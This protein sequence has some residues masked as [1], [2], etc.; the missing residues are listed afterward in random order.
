MNGGVQVGLGFDFRLAFG[1]DLTNYFYLDTSA[2]NELSLDLEVTA[3]GLSATGR[4]GLLD[5]NVT[6]SAGSPSSFTASFDVDL[7]DPVGVNDGDKLT[8]NE[9]GALG[10]NL[11][12]VFDAR[13]SGVADVNLDTVVSF[14]SGGRFPSL[15]A[16]FNLDW[17]F[18]NTDTTAGGTGFGSTPQ[19]AFNNVRL[20]VGQFLSGFAKP[21]L[22]K[23]RDLTEPLQPIIDAL[24]TPI[25]ILSD[26]L[27][28]N[29][30]L[31]DV[32]DAA[33]D[34]YG[35]IQGLID[36]LPG[37]GNFN[38]E[39][40][41]D[42]RFISAAADIIDLVNSIPTLGPNVLI[43]LGSFDLS[44]SDP[45]MLSDLSGVT[46]GNVVTTNPMDE[47]AN[48]PDGSAAVGFFTDAQQVGGGDSPVRFPILEN[49]FEA[50][51]LLLGKSGVDLFIY[52]PLALAAEYSFSVPWVIPHWKFSCRREPQGRFQ[53]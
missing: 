52:D 46:P 35:V 41:L 19:V 9:L 17:Q 24:Q 27:G 2:A 44:G 23:I 26:A 40:P 16:E 38:I 20:D 37:G 39:T 15:A 3:P 25:P 48:S 51:K 50:F 36:Q 21:V 1:V 47:L 5:L 14:G 11:A 32:A 10:S 28:S 33:Q 34:F 8:L 6:D 7:I 22:E 43:P 12:G 45:R 4:L 13:F 42:I 30:T 18:T 53:R 29:V 49:P 31:L